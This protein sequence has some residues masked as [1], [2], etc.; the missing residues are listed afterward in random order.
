MYAHPHYVLY[1]VYDDILSID[2]V[3]LE[4]SL[5]T[6]WPMGDADHP[7][8]H[9]HTH[10]VTYAPFGSVDLFVARDGMSFVPLLL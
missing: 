10:S 9:T 4:L 2:Q 5:S 6:A 8:E 3:F 7:G 1:T